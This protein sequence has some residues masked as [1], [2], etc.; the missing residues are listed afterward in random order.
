MANAAQIIIE[1]FGGV[2]AFSRA[3]NRTPSTV[4]YW[5]EK[6]CIPSKNRDEVVAA[7]RK[8]APDLVDV[9]VQGGSV[10]Q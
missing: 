3:V 2:S 7:L 1:L 10:Q 5:K 4:Q 9:A 8:R 6:G